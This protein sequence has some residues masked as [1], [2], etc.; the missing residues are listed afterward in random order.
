MKRVL[1]LA[2]ATFVASA[3][4]VSANADSLTPNANLVSP[5]VASA[6]ANP[7]YFGTGN[8]NGGFEVD[9]TNSSNIEVGLRAKYRSNPTSV[10]TSSNDIYTVVAGAQTQVTSGGNGAA[11]N[12]A[13]WNYDFSIDLRPDGVGT[14][15]LADIANS[16]ITFTDVTTGTTLI[17]NGNLFALFGGDAS[18]YG[19]NGV[20]SFSSADW[21]F[22][23][24]ENPAFLGS[25]FNMNAPDLYS[26][27]INVV[28]NAGAT[29]ATDTIDVQVAPLPSAATMGLGMLTVIGAAGLLRKKLRIA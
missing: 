26:I 7:I 21:G 29:L 18:T 11:S 19:K 22:Q 10:L 2:I 1:A 15:T 5:D 12:R 23:N 9:N 3:A 20:E 8:L 27:L 13:A 24:S 25:A 16:T 17:N 6:N 28:N 4:A 14:L